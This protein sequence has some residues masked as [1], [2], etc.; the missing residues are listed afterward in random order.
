M[1]TGNTWFNTS[2]AIFRIKH[3]I[4]SQRRF[5]IAPTVI[6][7]ESPP[8][9][10][11]VNHGAWL[12]RCP[13]PGCKGAE[14]VWE[15]GLYYCFSCHNSSVGHKIRRSLFPQERRDIEKLL[16]Q[17][18]L[19]NRNWYHVDTMADLQTENKEHAG[20]L[21]NAGKEA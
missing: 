14:Y 18:P 9:M 16:E 15:E 20:E 1:I 2:F 17:R 6:D 11:F 10:A 21:I 19:V 5:G 12:V 8:V 7:N 4:R 3:I 13:V